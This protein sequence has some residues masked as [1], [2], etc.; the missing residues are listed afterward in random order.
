MGIPNKDRCA[1]AACGSPLHTDGAFRLTISTRF[2]HRKRVTHPP[3]KTSAATRGHDALTAL[4]ETEQ[5]LRE[6]MD[7]AAAEAKRIV[8]G[9]R[10]RAREAEAGLEAAI[11]REIA[12]LDVSHA[13]AVRGELA[14][15]AE[16]ARRDAE[17]FAGVSDAR[18]AELAAR[19]LERVFGA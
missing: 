18:A 9:A 15:I 4:L 14:A 1:R 8:D 2:R 3:S 10:D 5:T 13:A 17:K 7:A 6:R 16:A 19:V 11:A 12:A